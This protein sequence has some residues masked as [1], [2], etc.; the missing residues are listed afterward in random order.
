MARKTTITKDMILG[1]ALTMVIRDGYQSVNVKT[2][3]AEIGCSTQPIVWH[4]EN[5]EGFRTELYGYAREY[6]GRSIRQASDPSGI[7][8]AMGRSYIRMAVREPNLF[9]FLYLGQ[10]PVSKPYSLKDLTTGKQQKMMIRGIAEQT[11]LTEEQAA[12]GIAEQT[13]LT[14]EQAARCIKDTV[15]YSH[16]LA[17][18]VATGVF[19]ASE[20]SLMAMV[21][22]A[23]EGFVKIAGGE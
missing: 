13:G 10:T 3:A 9:K 23:S 4:F 14:E 18:M 12:R 21:M 17:T 7:F 19:K 2:L 16:G 5:M 20:K 22:R 1:S 6:A 11:G 8:E 15:I